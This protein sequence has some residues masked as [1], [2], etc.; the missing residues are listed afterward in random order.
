MI[1]VLVKLFFLVSAQLYAVHEF[2]VF[3]DRLSIR[4][5]FNPASGVYILDYS[6]H[7]QNDVN[8]RCHDDFGPL[9][10]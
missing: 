8:Q 9:A 1:W 5:L 2:L 6:N 10:F 7:M 3:K 4:H